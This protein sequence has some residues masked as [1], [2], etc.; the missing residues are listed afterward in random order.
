M[1]LPALIVALFLSVASAKE[2]SPFREI[3]RDGD[4][5]VRV[6]EIGDVPV[7]EVNSH[8]W[9][10]YA[11]ILAAHDDPAR[12][13]TPLALVH[14]DSHSDMQDGTFAPLGRA[15]AISNP[16]LFLERMKIYQRRYPEEGMH[17]DSYIPPSL[18]FFPIGRILWLRPD[19]AAN[20]PEAGSGSYGIDWA[21]VRK[22][23][24]V[25]SFF[26]SPDVPIFRRLFSH[27]W[28]EPISFEK[29]RS[30]FRANGY[31]EESTGRLTLDVLGIEEPI[32][33]DTPYI[34]DID[35]DAFSCRNA[36]TRADAP[37]HPAADEAEIRERVGELVNGLRRQ[38]GRPVAISIATSE[39][40][41]GPG[42][43][44]RSGNF[45]PVGDIPLI[46]ENLLRELNL[47]LSP[48]RP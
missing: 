11:W 8:H 46:R 3:A 42:D 2:P 32:D 15:E 6:T 44:R 38:G 26:S 48:P 33:I 29:R 20:S 17:N 28:G 35:M 34:L 12:F 43:G 10:L 18:S 37:E 21:R 4:D 25:L 16:A 30:W 24:D 40:W 19:F 41:L 31:A 14:V 5:Y 23:G 45:T 39:G 1:R 36:S 13:E 27:I 7:Y 22:E 47:W 9:A